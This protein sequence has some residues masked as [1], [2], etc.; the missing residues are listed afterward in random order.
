MPKTRNTAARRKSGPAGQTIP[1]EQAGRPEPGDILAVESLFGE[2]IEFDSMEQLQEQLRDTVKP[3]ALD[4]I[5]AKL[6]AQNKVMHNDDGTLTWI[7]AGNNEK[8][9]KS[10]ERSIPL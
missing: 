3:K 9:L 2:H 10:W 6:L 5:L 4:A 7:H 1:K 8:L